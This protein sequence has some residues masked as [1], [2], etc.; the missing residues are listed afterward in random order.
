[1]S[2]IE[3]QIWIATFSACYA[4][5]IKESMDDEYCT[6][7]AMQDANDAI[8][9]LKDLNAEILEDNSYKIPF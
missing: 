7:S 4:D 9:N 3:K 8:R 6:K 2:E 5:Y 1:M